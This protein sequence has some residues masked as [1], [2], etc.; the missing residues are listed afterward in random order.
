MASA[1][2]GLQPVG[3]VS[4]SAPS[5]AATFG[6]R[7]ADSVTTSV[8]DSPL[9]WS[10]LQEGFSRITLE[11]LGRRG[12]VL[13]ALS[14]VYAGAM[15]G[16]LRA[17]AGMDGE[18]V[19]IGGAAKMPGIHRVPSRA[20]L[21]RALGGTLTSLNVRM[22]ASWLNHCQDGRLTSPATDGS[23]ERWA[24]RVAVP[25]RYDRQALTD[26]DVIVFIKR[27]TNADPGVSRT[28][29]LRTLRDR[30]QACEQSRF[31][32]LYARTMGNNQ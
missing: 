13:M 27:E 17:L 14:E 32:S 4:A 25:E 21:R 18:A 23:W 5:Y 12:P 31:A 7:H 16:E 6:V 26:E 10:E 11:E 24:S 2:L 19:L 28:R 29:L 20:G 8:A 3:P 22:A 1:G 30:G 9:W 15:D